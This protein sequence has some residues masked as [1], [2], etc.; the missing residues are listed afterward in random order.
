M[1]AEDSAAI[2]AYV[3]DRAWKAYSKQTVQKNRTLTISI[4]V[5]IR[6]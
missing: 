4:F 2:H 1:R 3:I 5:D 6:R